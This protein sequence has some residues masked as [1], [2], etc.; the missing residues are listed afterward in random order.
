MSKSD[1]LARTI[2]EKYWNGGWQRNFLISFLPKI[3]EIGVKD[4]LVSY[5]SAFEMREVHPLMLRLPELWKNFTVDDWLS[6][7]RSI[8][9]RPPHAMV[10][11]Q[12]GDVGV[13]SDI[14]FLCHFLEIDGLDLYLNHVQTS[15]ENK[16]N[17]IRYMKGF[18]DEFIKEPLDY[19]DLSEGEDNAFDGFTLKDLDQVKQSLLEDPRTKE[20]PQDEAAARRYVEQLYQQ[21]TKVLQAA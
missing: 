19:E 13:H 12:I 7:M 21:Y 5:M 6:I 10:K 18:L 8:D 11:G 14:A 16:Q 4:F 20:F 1:E 9:N 2:Y 15:E 17:T 3:E